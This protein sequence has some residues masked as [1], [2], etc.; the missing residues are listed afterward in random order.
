LIWEQRNGIAFFGRRRGGGKGWMDR[1]ELDWMDGWQ[2]EMGFTDKGIWQGE[3]GE[4]KTKTLT[5][6]EGRG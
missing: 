2:R 4:S 5:A 6:S 1:I 3:Q